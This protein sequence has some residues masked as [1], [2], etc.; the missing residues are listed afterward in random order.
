MGVTVALLL[1]GCG[2]GGGEETGEARNELR[3][4]M[5]VMP[6]GPSLDP[7]LT[8]YGNPEMANLYD[9]LTAI[10]ADGRIVPGLA[11]EWKSVDP[12]TWRFT[13]RKGVRFHNGEEFTA[14]DVVYS[15]ERMK[16]PANE[17]TQVTQMAYLAGVKKVDDYTVDLITAQPYAPLPAAVR[18]QL[19]IV[20]KDY[21]EK[22]GNAAF[23]KAPVGTGPYK[24]VEWVQDQRIVH[25][26]NENYWAGAPKIKKITYLSAP[27]ASTRT[28]MLL[29]GEADLIEAV[30]DTDVKRI[31]S[32]SGKQIVRADTAYINYIGINALKPPFDDVWVRQAMNYAVDVETIINSVLGGNGTLLPISN[33][34]NHAGFDPE[35]KPY[36]YD[37]DRAK[38]LLAEVGL[39]ANIPPQV[40]EVG[41][42]RQPYNAEVAQAVAGYLT[43]VGIPTTVKVMESAAQFE[44]YVGGK[45]DSLAYNGMT[46]FALDSDAI[47]TLMFTDGSRGSQYFDT[48]KTSDLALKGQGAADP[49]KRA[50][51]YREL[52][53]II[54]EEAPHIFLFQTIDVYAASDRL[55]WDGPVATRE[56]PFATAYFK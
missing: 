3:V 7:M 30:L 39:G 56:M 25:A 42:G 55:V 5:A 11:T 16:D 20:P 31:E 27:E 15:F 21:I 2:S 52:Q 4:A 13:L 43:E 34:T 33:S 51:I 12:T 29:A 28:S 14:D 6:K 19:R 44:R 45:A 41:Q 23:A 8:T 40:I 17:S 9:G 50:E 26:A 38:A 10:D 24:F 49:A 32:A 47:F 54:R 22:V 53:Q 37:P 35:L 36:P 48:S 46:S 1:A 18:V